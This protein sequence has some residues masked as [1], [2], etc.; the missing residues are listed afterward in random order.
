MPFSVQ[1]GSN[2]ARPA[3]NPAPG[4]SLPASAPNVRLQ[5]PEPPDHPHLPSV[6]V[7]TREDAIPTDYDNGP[8][9]SNIYAE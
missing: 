4:T 5:A 1:N 8:Y 3:H 6:T 9:A 7:V 2:A